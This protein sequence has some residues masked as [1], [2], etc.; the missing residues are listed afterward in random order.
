MTSAAVG[1]GARVDWETIP[2]VI[3][4]ARA[5]MTPQLWDGTCGGSGQEATVGRNTAALATLALRPRVLTGVSTADTRSEFLGRTIRAPVLPAPVGEIA[6]FHPGGAL[7][8]ARAAA[9]S[10]TGAFIGLVSSPQMEDVRA[11]CD[12]PLILQIY[13][14]GDDAW[15]RRLLKRAEDCGMD[16]ICL[17]VDTPVSGRLDRDLRH[18][19]TLAPRPRPNLEDGGQ[20]NG[21]YNGGQL[22]WADIEQLRTMTQLPLILKGITHPV[23]AA[24]AVELGAD[25]VCIS[26]HGGRQLDDAQ[27]TIEVLPEIAAAVAGRAGLII[28]GGFLRGSD[29][30]KALA[31][32]ADLVL[33]GKLAV[34]ALAAGGETGLTRALDI[35]TSEIAVNMTNLGIG[36]VAQLHPGLVCRAVSPAETVWPHGRT[37]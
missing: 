10:G 8:Y 27:G 25:Y 19:L 36:T 11:S 29:V 12:G 16:G 7:A 17:T 23:D 33:I 37:R 15:L 18:R 2:E 1:L 35:L 5:A 21:P 9:V 4:A 30:I 6:L 34:L 14:F 3:E 31:L 22:T 28:D 26:N 24:Q 13:R 32:G 20:A